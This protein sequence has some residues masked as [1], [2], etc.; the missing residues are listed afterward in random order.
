MA[1]DD[2]DQRGPIAEARR[3]ESALLHAVNIAAQPQHERITK[4]VATRLLKM[5]E[6]TDVAPRYYLLTQFARGLNPDLVTED[7]ENVLR[8]HE[9]EVE[10]QQYLYDVGHEVGTEEL[11]PEKDIHFEY[12]GPDRFGEE[13]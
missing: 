8:E 6:E 3:L 1:Y 2:T 4:L 11:D 7:M 5:A 9:F 10:E 13:M 12:T